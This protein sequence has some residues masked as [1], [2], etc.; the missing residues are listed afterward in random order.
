MSH[1]LSLNDFTTE[2]II[3]VLDVA[4][5]M[6]KKRGTADAV[7]PLAGKSIAMIFS[8]S[9]TRTRVS[10]EVG[11]GELG[12]HAMYF[13]KSALQLGRGEPISDTAK[14]L[15]RYVHG[16]VIRYHSHEEVAELANYS[17]APVINA[18]TDKFHPCQLLA[19]LMTIREYKGKLDGVRVAYLGDGA[20]N[21]AKSWILAAKRTGIDLR[22][23]APENYQPPMSFVTGAKGP[24][25]ITVTEDPE[26]AIRDVH[27][28]YTDV[29][30]SMGFEEEAGERLTQLKPYQVNRDLMTLASANVK[31]MHCLPAYR[32]KE[33][34]ADVID[35]PQSI[36]FDEA[37]NRLHAQKAVL[38][39]L[40]G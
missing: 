30:V 26:K 16:I 36:I 40:I 24:G 13:D 4:E 14:V 11:I 9:S 20:S 39:K 31:F 25:N 22:I 6:K 34:T 35:G 2:E 17:A 15:E 1:L 23:G 18:L 32:G 7:T 28:V 10:F 33:V 27:F 29:W 3:D 38:A 5:D 8:K 21:M 37:E 19:D 12:G